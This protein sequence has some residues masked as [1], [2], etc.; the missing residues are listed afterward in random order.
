MLTFISSQQ[1]TLYSMDLMNWGTTWSLCRLCALCN[2]C[3]AYDM[4]K[5]CAIELMLKQHYQRQF[6]C[7]ICW[8]ESQQQ[9]CFETVIAGCLWSQD[10]QQLSL[11]LFQRVIWPIPFPSLFLFCVQGRRNWCSRPDKFTILIIFL[12]FCLPRRIL[13]SGSS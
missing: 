5:S 8:H 10:W 3:G 1:A 4:R 11:N 6:Y 13:S 7:L 2:L 9:S 12:C